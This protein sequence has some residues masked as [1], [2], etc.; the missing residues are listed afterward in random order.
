MKKL[1]LLTAN[2]IYSIASYAQDYYRIYASTLGKQDGYNSD[3]KW[4]DDET[5]NMEMIIKGNV[6]FISDEAGSTY[7]LYETIDL[8]HN[9]KIRSQSAWY[10]RDEK[11]RKMIVKIVH[12]DSYSMIYVIYDNAAVGYYYRAK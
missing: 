12:Y 8:R 7:S 3:F 9:P 10:A 4:S 11:Q 5:R 2:L 6:I 1:L